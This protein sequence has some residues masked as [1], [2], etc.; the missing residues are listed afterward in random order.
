[1]IGPPARTRQ[2]HAPLGVILDEAIK[3]TGDIRPEVKTNVLQRMRFLS[4][5]PEESLQ[6]EGSGDHKVVLMDEHESRIHK[7]HSRRQVMS[8]EEVSLT[9]MQMR[10]P[11]IS[12][13]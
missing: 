9:L 2:W 8:R 10:V 11:K 7:L 1:M 13:R 3:T 6:V 4:H 12:R 5:R